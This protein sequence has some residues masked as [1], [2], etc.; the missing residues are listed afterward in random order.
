M[1]GFDE[2]GGEINE[3][4]MDMKNFLI[5]YE[6]T[7]SIETKKAMYS[8]ISQVKMLVSTCNLTDLEVIF[9]NITDEMERTIN[10]D[11]C[12]WHLEKYQDHM[13]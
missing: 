10:I 3:I 1:F 7:A 2:H 9:K 12:V 13:T 8:I 6:D 11:N 4:L 5:T